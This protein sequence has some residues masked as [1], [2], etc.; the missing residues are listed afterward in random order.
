MWSITKV[1][2]YDFVG[3][4]L[5]KQSCRPRNGSLEPSRANG[6]KW[7]RTQ[8]NPTPPFF[9]NTKE[10]CPSIPIPTTRLVLWFWVELHAR[11]HACILPSSQFNQCMCGER[12]HIGIWAPRND[13]ELH[14]HTS[15]LLHTSDFA[16]SPLCSMDVMLNIVFHKPRWKMALLF[17]RSS[18]KM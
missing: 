9:W 15:P 10:D 14:K 11:C 8:P 13:I 3:S 5:Y 1:G 2:L 4:S 12:K 18:Y 7:P 6:W 17:G 16:S